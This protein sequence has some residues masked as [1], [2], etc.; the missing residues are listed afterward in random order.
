M[1]HNINLDP[2][3]INAGPENMDNSLEPT[4]PKQNVAMDPN[5]EK[6]FQ[7]DL[8][9]ATFSRL[10][11]Y[12]RHRMIHTIHIKVQTITIIMYIENMKHL[13]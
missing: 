5:E 7:C 10:G 11:N 13:L 4:R 9:S 3:N 2:V 8:C 12:T 6:P 1:F